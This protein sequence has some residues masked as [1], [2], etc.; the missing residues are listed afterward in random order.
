VEIRN[1]KVKII[2]STGKN[3][4]RRQDAP[5]TFDMNASIYI[6]TRKAILNSRSLYNK[7]TILYEMPAYR[8]IDIDSKLDFKIVEFLLKNKNKKFF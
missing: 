5:Q 2:K 1:K 6:W 7:K 8:S 3:I 4:F